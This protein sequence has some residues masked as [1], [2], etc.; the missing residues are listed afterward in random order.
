META[1]VQTRALSIMT[2]EEQ[3]RKG[4]TQ[5]I[6]MRKDAQEQGVPYHMV[7]FSLKPHEHADIEVAD[8]ES[9]VANSTRAV[10]IHI[11]SCL[12]DGMTFGSSLAGAR[13]VPGAERKEPLELR[14]T[15]W[16]TKI[17]Q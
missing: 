16:R 7:T 10:E 17:R 9:I 12:G 5:Y 1:C 11:Q 15:T 8:T 2:T 3:I 13:L 6:T 14:L 4:R